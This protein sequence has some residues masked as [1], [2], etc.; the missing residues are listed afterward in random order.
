MK[1]AI[2][3]VGSNSIRLLLG[4]YTDGQWH[5]E[6]KR[7]WTTRLGKRNEDGSLTTES[8]DASYK[9]FSEIA[10]LAKDYGVDHCLAFATSAV[11]EASNGIAFMEQAMTYCSMTY[12]ILSGDEEAVYGFRGALQDRLADGL[13]YATIDIGGGSTE[14]VLKIA[15]IGVGPI[16]LVRYALD[17]FRMKAL[18]KYGKKH[19]F[20]GTP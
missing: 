7:L 2:I 17:L 6:P 15:S 14:L 20:Y 12:R 3:D 13:H 9:A 1:A 5:N 10:T 19:G 4:T 16:R 18:N 8:M 11:R